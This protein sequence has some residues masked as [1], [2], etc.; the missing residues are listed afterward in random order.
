MAPSVT[1]LLCKHE[2]LD[3]NSWH[4]HKKLGT[5]VIPTRGREQRAPGIC[6]KRHW[7]GE[8]R[9][10]EALSQKWSWRI[11]EDDLKS[12]SGF[13][14]W[15]YMCAH[16]LEHLHTNIPHIHNSNNKRF[17]NQDIPMTLGLWGG[18]KTKEGESVQDQPQLPIWGSL[19]YIRLSFLKSTHGKT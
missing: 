8:L 18:K 14:E 1:C 7:I 2:E 6:S 4:T 17:S 19:D 3:S 12:T 15:A 10:S 16:T 11:V 5:P 9:F 13:H